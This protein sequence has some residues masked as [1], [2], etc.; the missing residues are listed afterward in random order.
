[1][2]LKHGLL[3]LVK[4]EGA[5]TGYELDKIFKSSLANFWTAKT[6][7]IYRELGTM[8]ELGWLTSERII[9]EDKPNKRQYTITEEGKAELQRWLTAPTASLGGVK[10]EF[11]MRIFFSADV[12]KENTISIL[13]KIKE[14]CL[15]AMQKH[16]EIKQMLDSFEKDKHS[17][18]WRLTLLQ[19]EIFTKSSMEWAEQSIEILK[20]EKSGGN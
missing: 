1:M 13:E 6:S 4:Y 16:I 19:G 2:S 9:Q 5:A 18:Y 10:S 14:D 7:Q 3:G 20:N 8:E 15:N 11:L 12:P 17:V